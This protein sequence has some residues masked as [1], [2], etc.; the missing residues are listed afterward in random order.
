MPAHV[1]T[2]TCD[3]ARTTNR[4][5][6]CGTPSK[7]RQAPLIGGWLCLVRRPRHVPL[8]AE[9]SAR[10][11]GTAAVKRRAEHDGEAEN[12]PACELESAF[13]DVLRASHDAGA[14]VRACVRATRGKRKRRMHTCAFAASGGHGR[15]KR[16]NRWDWAEVP[17]SV[18]RGQGSLCTISSS[19]SSTARSACPRRPS[20]TRLCASSSCRRQLSLSCG[21]VRHGTFV[22]AI[23]CGWAC[24]PTAA[25]EQ[26]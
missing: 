26:Y 13:G 3:A 11:H 1:L 8:P 17:Q 10:A 19:H 14:C 9:V 2:D 12:R 6:A 4:Q 15:A 20:A 23:V 24:L 22:I 21:S 5:P 7:A 16:P 18:A 25:H